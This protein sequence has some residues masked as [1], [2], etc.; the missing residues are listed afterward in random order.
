MSRTMESGI[1]KSGTAEHCAVVAKLG[2]LERRVVT[3]YKMEKAVKSKNETGYDD[4]LVGLGTYTH[5]G[6]LGS[7]WQPLVSSPP[8]VLAKSTS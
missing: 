1:A 3:D 6:A 8:R 4:G 7:P 2:C 5:P